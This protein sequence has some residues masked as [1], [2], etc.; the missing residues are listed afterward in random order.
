MRNSWNESYEDIL[1]ACDFL[2][3]AQIVL[4]RPIE[5][6]NPLVFLNR[7]LFLRNARFHNVG[8]LADWYHFEPSLIN[9]AYASYKLFHVGKFEGFHE[10]GSPNVVTFKHLHNH[11]GSAFVQLVDQFVGESQ[12]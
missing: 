6:S 4:E 3:Q 5:D 11:H 1:L 12:N 7:A 8:H 2:N 10:N 9:S